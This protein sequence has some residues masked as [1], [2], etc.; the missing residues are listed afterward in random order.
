MSLERSIERRWTAA[1]DSEKNSELPSLSD[2]LFT[3]RTGSNPPQS[4]QARR[5]SSMIFVKKTAP[6][7]LQTSHPQAEDEQELV[8]PSIKKMQPCQVP[9]LSCS[10]V[11]RGLYQA[12]GPSLLHVIFHWPL[13]SFLPPSLS[14]ETLSPAVPRE[15]C[16]S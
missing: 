1:P 11:L 4:K 13:P 6:K 12:I 5:E 8:R 2:P 14:L 15:S 10:M 16:P 7:L 9:R 3:I